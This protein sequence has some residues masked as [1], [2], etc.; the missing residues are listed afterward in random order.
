MQIDLLNINDQKNSNVY[1]GFLSKGDHTINFT[2]KNLPAG[3]YMLN[4]NSKISPS[5][6]KIVVK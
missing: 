1:S 5:A 6:I 3:V 4:V 2:K